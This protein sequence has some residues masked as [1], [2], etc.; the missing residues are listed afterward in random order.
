[1]LKCITHPKYNDID[2]FVNWLNQDKLTN[3]QNNSLPSPT[4]Q[5]RDESEQ[6]LII[7]KQQQKNI[8]Q[9]KSKSTDE[10]FEQQQLRLNRT[11]LQRTSK[12]DEISIRGFGSHSPPIIQRNERQN[13]RALS[14][15]E[16]RF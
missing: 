14:E 1:M 2:E 16:L 13:I 9:K 8:N 15:S 6:Q 12:I 3:Q 7:K 5:K 4:Y 11:P 10:Q